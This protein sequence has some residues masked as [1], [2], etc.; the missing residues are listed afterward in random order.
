MTVTKS[1]IALTL[2]TPSI[3]FAKSDFV[4]ESTREAQSLQ[5]LNDLPPTTELGGFD[6][7]V[8]YVLAAPDQEDA[9]TC[10]YMSVTGIAEWWLARMNPESSRVHDGPLDLS[11]RYT[12]NI[13]GSYEEDHTGLR[14]WRTDTITLFN[15]VGY[16]AVRNTSFRFTKGWFTGS[17]NDN[18]ATPSSPNAPGATY[19]SDFNWI[20]QREHIKDGWMNMPIFTT[21]ILFEDPARNQWNIGV[22][23]TEIVE[24]VKAALF[25]NKA[26]V[27][28]IYNHNGY[29]HSVYVIGYNDNQDNGNCE[30]T[31]NFRLKIADHAKEF[32]DAAENATTPGDFEYWN[33]RAKRAEEARD[34]IED[35]WRERNGCS[36]RQGVFYV[37]DSIYPDSGAPLYDY[38]PHNKGEELRYTKKIVFKEYDWLRYLANNVTQVLATPKNN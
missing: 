35:L 2:M 23:P 38:D 24:Q 26:P 29:W 8:P 36:S 17:I 20:D 12:I 5:C 1:L 31:R 4:F 15:R 33:T 9:G 27:Q 19:S 34:K 6:E 10:L 22:T 21:R 7:L 3:V 37:R 14:N 32:R 13:A 11:E 28:V 30:F 16:K 25:V 18:N